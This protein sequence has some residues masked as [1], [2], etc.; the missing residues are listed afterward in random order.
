MFLGVLNIGVISSNSHF[1]IC[2]S[3]A[4]Q[5]HTLLH[6][7]WNLNEWVLD[8]LETEGY[9]TPAKIVDR[10]KM[11]AKQRREYANAIVDNWE[12]DG[13]IKS[14]YRDFK[15]QREVAREAKGSGGSGWSRS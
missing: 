1:R 14:L 2:K 4:E 10:E 15:G 9:L 5:A 8:N 7:K 13:Q 12:R 6:W 3:N 11:K